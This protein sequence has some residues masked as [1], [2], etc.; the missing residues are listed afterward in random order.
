MIR[1]S[2][3]PTTPF[4]GSAPQQDLSSAL[5]VAQLGRDPQDARRDDLPPGTAAGE[6]TLAEVIGRGAFGTVYRGIHSLIGKE[7]AVKVLDRPHPRLDG[8]ERR[9]VAEARAVNRIRHPNIVDIFGFGELPNGRK[10]CVMELLVGESLRQLTRRV[11]AV[12]WQLV[13]KILAPLSDALDAAH[14]AGILHRDLKP[15]N[16]FIHRLPGGE[17]TVKLLDFGIAKNL[18]VDDTELTAC[19]NVIGTPAYMAP[20]R[21][22]RAPL[23]PA[24][25][26]YSLGVI[27]YELLTGQQPFSGSQVLRV[28]ESQSLVT[29][30]PPS[31]I[32]PLLSAAVDQALIAMLAK[33]PAARPSS[34]REAVAALERALAAAPAAW[35]E[36][37]DAPTLVRATPTL[38]DPEALAVDVLPNHASKA[39]P[40]PARARRSGARW[41]WAAAVA[42]ASALAAWGVLSSESVSGWLVPAGSMQA[43]APAHRVSPRAFAA[44]SSAPLSQP[45]PA[46]PTV[47]AERVALTIDGA[48]PG[49]L[50]YLDDVLLGSVDQPNWVPRGVT[51]MRLRVVAKERQSRDHANVSERPRGVKRGPAAAKKRPSRAVDSTSRS[52]AARE[53]E[54]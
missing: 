33:T 41:P 10:F 47:Q 19:G 38:L 5:L 52:D 18:S 25:D 31:E 50:L 14:Q 54:F 46:A 7:V 17:A 20:E 8:V 29:P 2:S 3:H 44:R 27:A 26:I 13:L 9:F 24:C 15:A 4:A 49:A 12:P 51:A 36:E 53:L 40:E 28:M 45:P 35:V 30:T 22:G 32:N 34:A 16:V 48:P 37:G 23:T 42:A 43:E 39:A 1:Q 21:W 6:Y 11:G